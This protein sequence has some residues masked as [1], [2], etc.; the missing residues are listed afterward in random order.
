MGE[1]RNPM[2]MLGLCFAVLFLAFFYI[3]YVFCLFTQVLLT[4]GSIVMGLFIF[5][6]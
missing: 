4:V 2:D 6:V 3:I 1:L 5:L